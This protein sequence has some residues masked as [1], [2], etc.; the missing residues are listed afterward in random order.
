MKQ[1]YNS[2]SE[3]AS[4]L[5]ISDRHLWNQIRAE[6]SAIPHYRVG[7]RVLLIPEEVDAAITRHFGPKQ[8]PTK[9]KS[10]RSRKEVA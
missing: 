3:E 8:A 4:R 2:V 10:A 9:P 1:N 6:D 7:R 5:R